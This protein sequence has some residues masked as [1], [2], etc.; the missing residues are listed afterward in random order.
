MG[1][2]AA[3]HGQPRKLMYPS[4]SGY[5]CSWQQSTLQY[6]WPSDR[7]LGVATTGKPING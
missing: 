4:M 5:T 6:T 3:C 2:D 7:E 1:N